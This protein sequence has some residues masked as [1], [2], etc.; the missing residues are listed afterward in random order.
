LLIQKPKP[1]A[2][3]KKAP[4]KSEVEPEQ[5]TLLPSDG[6]LSDDELR[7]KIKSELTKEKWS[8]FRKVIGLFEKN[9]NPVKHD[10]AKC[11]RPELEAI[12]AEI[13]D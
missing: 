7:S 13:A 3:K 4:K 9:T 12:W 8:D 11:E 10:V 5:E 1:S 6:G 2:T